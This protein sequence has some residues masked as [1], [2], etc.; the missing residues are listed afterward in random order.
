MIGR[1]G[2]SAMNRAVLRSVRRSAVLATA[3]ALLAPPS[4]ASDLVDVRTVVGLPQTSLIAGRALVRRNVGIVA[5]SEFLDAEMEFTRC[6]PSTSAV[7]VSGD[8]ADAA[9]ASSPDADAAGGLGHQ[10]GLTFKVPQWRDDA[11]LIDLTLRS[12]HAAPLEVRSSNER[13]TGSTAGLTVTQPLGSIDAMLGYAVPVASSYTGGNWRSTFAGFAWHSGRGTTLEF[14]ADRGVEATT[15]AIDRTL[16][17]KISHVLPARG[18]RLAAWSTRALDDP[19]DR[20]RI[21]VGLDLAF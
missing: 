9:C 16:T 1:D 20:M 10:F 21:G 2:A 6:V 19:A 18:A 8:A 15:G 3:L 7:P 14:I 13:G 5:E 17:L 12:W 11:P 4:P